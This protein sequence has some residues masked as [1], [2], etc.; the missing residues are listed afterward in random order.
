[1]FPR[2][3]ADGHGGMWATW[4]IKRDVM[5]PKGIIDHKVDI[6]AAH[7]DGRAFTAWR[8]PDRTKSDGYVTHLYH[9]LLGR[10]RYWGFIGR[11]RRPQLVREASGDVWVLYERKENESLNAKGP[12][13]Q[14]LGKPLTG[15]GRNRTCLIDES[16]YNYTVSG[17]I[18]VDG[19]KLPIVGQIP[20]TEGYGDICSGNLILDR[21]RP[22]RVSPASAWAGWRPVHLPVLPTSSAR[23]EIEID[24]KTFRLYW[25]DTHCHSRFSGDAEGEVDECYVFGRQKAGL[26][27]MAVTDNDFIYDDAL[28]PSAWAVLRAQA[29]H[30]DRPKGFVTLLGYERSFREPIDGHMSPNHRIVLF[31]GDDGP[32]HRHT[33][34]GAD[35]ETGFMQLMAQTDAFIYPH[36]PTWRANPSSRLGGVEVTSSW[37]IY[38][39]AA[40]TI[41]R[42]IKVGH[43]FA[44]IGSSDTHR[45]VPGLGGSLTGLWA[46]E[47]SREGVMEALWSRRCFATN[48]E[49]IFLDVRI[50]GA[51]MGSAGI[52][53]A[54]QVSV[55]CRIAAPRVISSLLLRRDGGVVAT[56]A[57]QSMKG[58]ITFHDDPGPGEHFYYVEVHMDHV[59][60]TPLP[61]TAEAIS[62]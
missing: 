32:L 3:C 23:P 61:A 54:G 53:V 13:S 39:H 17:D 40:D 58:S 31:P 36:H 7:S 47:L 45:I 30:F 29:Q 56:Y 55:A 11:R 42:A 6:Y 48:G 5:D 51:P 37:G 46:E 26:D 60:H 34:P 62:R 1:M 52:T 27:F 57:A 9:G 35:S 44:F 33:E 18:V 43:Q 41:H 50:N 15:R 10:R 12:D 38:I 19:G 14:F 59:P 2:L 8:S 16:V 21:S 22:I 49:R 24:G 25:G 4:T 28:T 20:D